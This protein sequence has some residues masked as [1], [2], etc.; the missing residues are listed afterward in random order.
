MPLFK[1]VA[2]VGLGLIG[3]S[4][5]IVLRRRKLAS[6]VIGVSRSASTI[7]QAIR[8]GA[9]DQGTTEGSRAVTDADLV[10]ICTPVSTIVPTAKHLARYTKPGSILTDVG[11][12]KASIVSELQRN[13]PADLAFVGAHP[14]AGSEK[15]G[16]AAATHKLFDHSFC[17]ITPT[18]K[19]NDRSLA[20]IESLWQAVAGRIS[21]MSPKEHDRLMA[22]ASHL[23]HLLA[24]ALARATDLRS[25]PE[26]PRSFLDMTRIAK[27]D[28]DLWDDIFLSNRSQL[29]EAL[30]RLERQLVFLRR[31][32]KASHATS[33]RNFCQQA[34][35]KREALADPTG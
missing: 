13:L 19:T 5:G 9:I 1:R 35:Q 30:K 22:Q 33:L 4:L 32:L 7:N 18:S 16:L 20:L 31:S 10:V 21:Q 24:Y 23:P 6:R 2:I 27:S 15:R 12:T 28:P 34:K 26:V 14:I 25:L 11:S 29:L 8:L 17:I 3:G